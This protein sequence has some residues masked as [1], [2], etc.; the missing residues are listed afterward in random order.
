MKADRYDYVFVGSGVAGATVAQGL[1][2]HDPSTAILMLEAGPEVPAKDRR[3]WWDYVVFDRK[4][5]AYAYDQ[6]GET[7]STGNTRWD[8]AENR[9][10]AYGGSTVHWG[11]WCH[12]LKPE[13]FYLE[14]NT[15]EGAN[16]PF[17]Y[18]TLAE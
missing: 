13:D 12:R 15:G 10:M 8:F 18:N 5:Y 11:G 14:E 7:E 1:L 16:W 4:P 6:P 3:A 17:D 2:E 9:V